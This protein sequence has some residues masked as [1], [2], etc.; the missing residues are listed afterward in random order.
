V[1]LLPPLSI[2]DAQLA[3]CYDALAEAVQA[4]V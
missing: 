2:S 4:L 3:R 1:Y